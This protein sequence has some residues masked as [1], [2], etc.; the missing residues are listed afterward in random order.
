MFGMCRPNSIV[1]FRG[2]LPYAMIIKVGLTNFLD[3]FL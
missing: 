3:N 1:S 2:E